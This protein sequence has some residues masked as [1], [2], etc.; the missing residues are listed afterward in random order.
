MAGLQFCATCPPNSFSTDSVTCI[1][2]EGCVVGVSVYCV[3]TSLCRFYG[4]SASTSTSAQGQG[5]NY[6]SF[7]CYVCPHGGVCSGTGVTIATIRAAV[8]LQPLM[9]CV[10]AYECIGVR[11]PDIGARTTPR[12]RSISAWC[13]AR[14]WA[15]RQA[16]IAL[17]IVLGRCVRSAS[18]WS[19]FRC[20]LFDS[21]GCC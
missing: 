11:S 21:I 7:A 19:L 13:P 16:L 17:H 5:H 1:C 9:L 2:S 15:A 14:V 20:S 4:A 10:F 3:L 8:I 18:T 6:K 12:P